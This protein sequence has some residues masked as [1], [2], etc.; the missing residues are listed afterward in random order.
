[1]SHIQPNLGYMQMKVLHI[2]KFL[3]IIKKNQS[4][5]KTFFLLLIIL[6]NL[7]YGQVSNELTNE[8]KIYGLSKFWQEVNYNFVYL[9][10]VDRTEWNNQYKT[11]IT[12]VQNTQSDYEYYRLL[13]KFCALLKDGHTNV[14]FPKEIQDNI[15]TNEFGDFKFVLSNIDG[16]AIITNVSKNKKDEL[17]IGTEIIKVNGLPTNQ[18]IEQNVKPYISSSTEHILN[19]RSIEYLLEGYKG[20]TFNI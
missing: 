11:L 17:P 8:E 15:F 9:N 5:K 6:S 16:R 1:Y 2:N 18:F 7:T 20:S 3:P 12:E 4:M 13:Q 14:W 19:D 10:K